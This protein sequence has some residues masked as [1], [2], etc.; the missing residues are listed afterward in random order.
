M[1]F[2]KL[3]YRWLKEDCKHYVNLG[4]KFTHQKLNKVADGHYRD[5]WIFT[6]GDCGVWVLTRVNRLWE[7][8]YIDATNPK[9]FDIIK[10]RFNMIAGWMN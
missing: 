10:T 7:W 5:N 6:T 9:F 1:D 8:Q 3:I 2:S 4:F